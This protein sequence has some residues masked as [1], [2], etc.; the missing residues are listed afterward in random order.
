MAWG[1]KR[2]FG[3]LAFVGLLSGMVF[4][5]PEFRESAI[6]LPS[7]C[8]AIESR[9]DLN[10]DGRNDILVVFHR[11]ILI[12]FQGT[13]N[14]FPA[15]PSLELGQTIAIPEKY[16][17]VSVGKVSRDRGLQLVFFSSD[18]V[19]FAPPAAFRTEARVASAFQPLLQRTI[20]L[21]TAPILRYLDAAV[22]LNADG[23]SELLVPNSDQLEVYEPDSEFRY[24]LK[25]KVTMPM[26]TRQQTLMHR[27]PDLLGM[28]DFDENAPDFV[29]PLPSLKGWLALQ[30]SMETNSP[31][32]L[33]LDF[34][35]D[36]RLDILT[37]N[38][39][40]YR[41]AKG[42]FDAV[43]S[44]LL[45]RIS[46][47]YAVFKSRIIA[48]PNLADLNGDGIWDTFS[49]ESSAA[50][51]TPRTD[52]AVY[53]GK[54]DR[55]F[56]TKPDFTLHTRDL[57]YSE[58]VPL[59]DINGDGA[60][61]IALFHLDFQPASMESQLRAYLRKGLDG[62]LR[63]YLWDKQRNRFLDVYSFKQRVTVNYEMYGARQ[64]FQQ[65]AFINHDMDGDGK[66]DLVMKTGPQ[67]I[68]IYPN[69]GG[70]SGFDSKPKSVI[71][72]RYPFSSLLVDDLNN[73]KI[74]DVIVTGFLP[75][76]E[77]RTIYTFYLS[78]LRR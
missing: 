73:D 3:G 60:L 57:A 58:I 64:L 19:E 66:V 54:P 67:E 48:A 13:E 62:E 9:Y 53:L 16:A 49:V 6:N 61:D 78:T 39:V 14:T 72:T 76:H 36:K 31:Q 40:F 42:A 63:F 4:G 56:S 8:E 12:F 70:N 43:P 69:L 2:L 44:Q 77:G 74:G 32:F 26:S 17:A 51:L 18:G 55:S 24:S 75:E 46:T 11:R 10:G 50:K 5:Q 35:G 37:P 25:A 21:T 22:D 30:F 38:T 33:V 52:I 41:N 15:A 29:R 71:R 28:P 20:D 34:D 59:G 65:Q 7:S 1:I 45:Q 23:R 68:S 27:E 47:S